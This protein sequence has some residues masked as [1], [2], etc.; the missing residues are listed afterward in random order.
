MRHPIRIL[1]FAARGFAIS[2]PTDCFPFFTGVSHWPVLLS[3]VYHSK[4]S[5]STIRVPAVFL[6]WMGKG[7]VNRECVKATGPGGV[8]HRI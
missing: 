4:H 8:S 1:F 7:G 6:C 2:I 5:K 3:D